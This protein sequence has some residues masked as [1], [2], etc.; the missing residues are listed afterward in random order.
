MV[1]IVSRTEDASTNE[2]MDWLSY[3]GEQVVRINENASISNLTVEIN[4]INHTIRFK[5]GD[6]TVDLTSVKSF[7]FRRGGIHFQKILTKNC[8]SELTQSINTH[9]EN[10]YETLKEYLVFCLN[11]INKLGDYHQGNAN[12]LISLRVAESVGLCIPSTYVSSDKSEILNFHSKNHN[13]I[14][15]FIQDVIFLNPQGMLLRS[16]TERVSKADITKMDNIFSPSLIQ[17][18]IKKKY[19]IRVFYLQGECYA[20]AIFSQQDKQTRVDYRNYNHQCPNR[21]VPYILPRAIELKINRFMKKMNLDTGSIDM[22]VTPE[23]EYVFLEVNPV[24]QYDMV[25][26]PCNYHLHSK[27][28]KILI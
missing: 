11:Q 16:T 19:E 26:V 17:T 20:M 8:T 3:Y 22:I 25:S 28:A 27:I 13:V 21:M 1:I 10:E 12:K 4:N 2:V 7:W 9:L 5:V 6:I 24:G 18:E 15:K 14:T 23:L